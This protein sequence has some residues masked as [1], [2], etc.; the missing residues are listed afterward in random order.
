MRY[1]PITLLII[2]LNGCTSSLT[3][4][5]AP[6]RTSLEQATKQTC[7]ECLGTVELPVAFLT[8]FDAIEDQQLLDSV[9]GGPNQGML[10]QGKVYKAK[11]NIDITLYR[12]WNSTNPKSRLGKWW[13]FTRPSNEVAQYRQ[14]YEI[15]YQW[16]ALDK[17]T[18]C[19]L[20]AGA[21]IVVGNGQSAFC[22][23][24]LTYP[25]SAAQQVYIKD[26]SLVFDCSDYD[27]IFSW[28]PVSE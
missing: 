17:L 20:K 12:A 11:N 13:A 5:N 19:S 2:F 26:A 24:F 18:H 23:G 16:S 28:K 4:D 27:A 10:C 21:E 14:D 7:N 8:F 15:C 9:I 25:A 22:S 3:K 6:Y 1:I